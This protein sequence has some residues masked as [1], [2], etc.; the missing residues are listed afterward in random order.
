ME[1]CYLLKGIS[2]CLEAKFCSMRICISFFYA[3]DLPYLFSQQQMSSQQ[4]RPEESDQVSP[5]LSFLQTSQEFSAEFGLCKYLTINSSLL[6]S[7]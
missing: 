7:L 5:L 2:S 3:Y 1:V 4:M 6:F